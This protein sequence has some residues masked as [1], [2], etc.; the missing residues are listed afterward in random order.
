MVCDRGEPMLI[1]ALMGVGPGLNVLHV[2]CLPLDH[3]SGL[4]LNWR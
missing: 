4:R 2:L 3:T 1:L